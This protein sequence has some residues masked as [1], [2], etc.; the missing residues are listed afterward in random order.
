MSDAH[1]RLK[2]TQMLVLATAFW[3]VS[4][5]AMKALMMV[6]DGLLDGR[7]NWFF[8]ALCVVYRFGISAALVFLLCARTLH[9][10]TR[11][12]ISQGVGL[13]VF[14]GLGLLL[15][16]DGLK[17]TSASTSAFLTQCYC[18]L[19]PIY[20]SL[21]DRRRPS[22][23]IVA[24]CLLVMLGVAV[25]AGVDPRTLRLG[26]GEGETLLASVLFT[27]QILWLERPAFA[28][29]NVHHFSLVMFVA[30][31]VVCLPLA[32]AT[33]H[34]ASDWIRAYS[35]PSTLIYLG[36]LVF[37]CTLISFLLMNRWQ[38]HVGATVAGLIYCVEPVFASLY[39]LFMPGWFSQW[40]GVSYENESVTLSLLVGGG[41]ITVANVLVQLPARGQ[42][43]LPNPPTRPAPGPP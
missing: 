20:V 39:A 18:I 3:G 28:R 36:M 4:F 14:G 9:R 7:S 31:T 1:P 16:M 32:I 26:R 21:R 34:Q 2:A 11:L 6:Q 43:V 37:G 38:R 25:L 17:Y 22:G 10:L 30:M 27:G 5:P 8:V 19:L 40:S 42:P 33:T 29:N 12:E 23:R 41:L 24:G 35:A 13:G 15:Q